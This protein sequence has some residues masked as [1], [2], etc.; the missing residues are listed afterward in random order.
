MQSITTMSPA[1]TV[2]FS[3]PFLAVTSGAASP[4]AVL[5]A[6]AVSYLLGYSLAQISRHI[7]SAG[8]YHTF[9][10]RL[11]GKSL[12][13]MVAW[14]YLLFYPLAA[15]MLCALLGQT[16]HDI[17]LSEAHWS[18]PWWIP[19]ALMLVTATAITYRGLAL[20]IR[21][22]VALGLFELLVMTVLAI[23]GLA[24]PGPGGTSRAWIHAGGSLGGHN[25]FLAFIFS[26]YSFTGWDAAAALGEETANPKRNIPIAILGSIV[27]L[28]LFVMLTTW[29]QLAGW[30]TA[31]LGHFSDAHPLPVIAI[32]QRFWGV[33]WILVLLA[34][35]NSL[36]GATLA[37]MNAATRFMYDLGRSG[38]LPRSLNRLTRHQTPS[39]ALV[40]QTVISLAVLFGLTAAVGIENI[41]N[42]TGLLF[43]FTL[44]FVYIIGSMAVP[45][46][47]LTSARSEFHVVK[48]ILIPLIGGVA[49]MAVAYESLNPAPAAPLNWAL[50]GVLIWAGV[51]IACLAARVVRAR[52]PGAVGQAQVSPQEAT[53]TTNPSAIAQ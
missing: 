37:S 29:G 28:G 32:A 19:A 25:F 50:P 46:L 11:F 2:A 10:E 49:L 48:H 34:I 12:G 14:M 18:L 9:T 39:V 53:T 42:F 5:L 16:L 43:V 38:V 47:Y 52:R 21:F 13:F 36:F 15:G 23:W 41:Y 7:T 8:S 27:V 4:L 33:G 22:V 6:A 30:G 44:T 45:R 20:S 51:G 40:V 24:D 26:I 3:V 1:I 17:M 35:V 31:Q